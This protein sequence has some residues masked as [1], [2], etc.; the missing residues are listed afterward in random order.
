MRERR[1]ASK[2]TIAGS[3]L[4]AHPALKDPNFR[5]AV[6]LKWTPIVGQRI[7]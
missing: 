1:K 6:V 5:R 3:L 4:L 7:G 2:P